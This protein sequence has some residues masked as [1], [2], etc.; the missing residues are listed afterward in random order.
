MSLDH[1]P[2]KALAAKLATVAASIGEVPKSG[3]N[4]DQNYEYATETDIVLAV[5]QRLFDSGVMLF[6]S[7]VAV[8]RSDAGT[9]STGK[10][11]GMVTLKM[12]FT[13]V[14]GESGESWVCSWASEAMDTQD[15]ALAKALTGALKYFLRDTFLLA[16]GDFEDEIDNDGKKTGRRVTRL[17]K[18][19]AKQAEALRQSPPRPQVDPAQSQAF[20]RLHASMKKSGVSVPASSGTAWNAYS[21]WIKGLA[22]QV[23]GSQVKRLIDLTPE[24]LGAVASGIS[25]MIVKGDTQPWGATE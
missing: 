5:R 13:F 3:R 12:T 19:T 14:D 15:K 1:Q 11:K 9:S 10:S 8:E 24:Q 17:E 22:E 7:V 16:T 21:A 18:K 2:P 6:P 25:Q 4:N 20:A 23:L